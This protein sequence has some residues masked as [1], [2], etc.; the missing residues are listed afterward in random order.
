MGFNLEKPI[1]KNAGLILFVH[2]KP[3]LIN[4]RA[5]LVDCTTAFV[6]CMAIFGP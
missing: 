4:Y 1:R 3:S 6:V 5:I 2:Y